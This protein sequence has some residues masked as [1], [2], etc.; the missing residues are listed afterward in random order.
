MSKQSN[1]RGV[2]EAT[3]IVIGTFVGAVLIITLLVSGGSDEKSEPATAP[4]AAEN[5]AAEENT[6]PV[7][8]VEVAD[9]NPTVSSEISADKIVEANCALCHAAGLMNA[10]KIGDADQWAPRIAQG[11]DTLIHNAIN[12]IR[13]MPAKGGNAALSDEEVA[14]AV[15]HMVNASG[16]SF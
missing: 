3:A 14:A 8:Q 16:G 6:Q 15:V 10:P 11:K 9:A 1:L 7:A 13:T 12:G 2:I 5:S 4:M